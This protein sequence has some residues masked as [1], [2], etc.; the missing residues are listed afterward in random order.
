MALRWTSATTSSGA[1]GRCVGCDA[2]V[3][4][5]AS[6]TSASADGTIFRRENHDLFLLESCCRARKVFLQLLQLPSSSHQL[7]RLVGRLSSAAAST[8]VLASPPTPDLHQPTCPRLTKPSLAQ[9]RR[10]S[11]IPQ[12]CLALL[13]QSPT[14]SCNSRKAPALH[15]SPPLVVCKPL[16]KAMS[17]AGTPQWSQQDSVQHHRTC[18]PPSWRS[19]Y[20]SRLDPKKR[21]MLRKL[22]RR[23]DFLDTHSG[24]TKLRSSGNS[25]ASLSVTIYLSESKWRRNVVVLEG[26]VQVSDHLIMARGSTASTRPDASLVLPS[27][28]V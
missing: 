16:K 6:S 17:G 5:R 8:E 11:S 23:T 13:R 20:C 14:H 22:P 3:D 28:S 4:A 27:A 12:V 2:A 21:S 18:R 1:C 15:A 7:P 19:L 25:L 24:N 26:V 10:R 9:E